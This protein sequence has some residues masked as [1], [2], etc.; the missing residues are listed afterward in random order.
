MGDLLAKQPLVEALC[1]FNF[2]PSDSQVDLLDTNFYNQIKDE[3]PE[4]ATSDRS[5]FRFPNSENTAPIAQ[6]QLLQFKRPDNL[7]AVQISSDLLVIN[8][9]DYKSWED[10]KSLVLKMFFKYC[11][12]YDKYSLRSISLRYINH[13]HVPKKRFE[14]EDFL[15]VFPILP[16]PIDKDLIGFNQAYIFAYPELDATLTHQTGIALSSDNN[17]LLLLDLD[18][19]CNFVQSCEQLSNLIIWVESWLDK[20][21]DE[22]ESAFIASLNPEYY[23]SLRGQK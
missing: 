19:I 13:I 9:R 1:Q 5:L 16:S 7:A 6:I 22:V 14:V 2:N 20:A 17:V 4:R 11:E 15:T 23:E 18:I 8:L 12:T 21:H 3:F 10:F